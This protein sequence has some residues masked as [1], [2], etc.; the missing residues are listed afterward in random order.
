MSLLLALI[1]IS[2]V[3]WA[4]VDWMRRENLLVYDIETRKT[5]DSAHVIVMIGWYDGLT[6]RYYY[7]H[8]SKFKKFARIAK[9]RNQVIGFNSLQFDDKICAAHGIN[10]TTTYDV[11]QHARLAAQVQTKHGLKTGYSLDSLAHANLG[12][13]KLKE[14][15]GS[16]ETLW[17]SQQIDKLA[18]YC[19]QDV[20]L[21]YLLW[22]KR[23]KIRDP[24]GN[25]RQWLDLGRN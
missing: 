3:L 12:E 11:Y 23:R 21:T 24:N 14:T 5:E 7:E 10:V 2:F 8:D 13:G 15:P 19:L 22:K 6:R 17:Q 18:A 20:R 9:R 25:G 1:G 4:T 16:I